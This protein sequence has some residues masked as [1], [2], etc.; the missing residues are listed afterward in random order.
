MES[1]SVAKKFAAKNHYHVQTNQELVA[2]GMSNFVGSI[3]TAF[4]VGG[5]FSFSPK[6]I[7]SPVIYRCLSR[8]SLARTH[9]S[10]LPSGLENSPL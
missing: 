7:S 10:E 6:A 9:R 8:C 3:F 5:P 1:I 4:P 2:I